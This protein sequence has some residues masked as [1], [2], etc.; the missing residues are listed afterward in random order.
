MVSPDDEEVRAQPW[1]ARKVVFK[2]VEFAP[3]T[4]KK[5]NEVCPCVW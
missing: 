2:E 4:T 5:F 3:A 1:K